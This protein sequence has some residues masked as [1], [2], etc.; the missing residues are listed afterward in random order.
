[1]GADGELHCSSGLGSRGVVRDWK[2]LQRIWPLTRGE[3]GKEEKTLGDL[4][5]GEMMYPKYRGREGRG[6]LVRA[7]GG[8]G[9][10]KM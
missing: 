3:A 4:G 2:L 10:G 9:H 6:K 8:G 5:Q 7:G 1:M